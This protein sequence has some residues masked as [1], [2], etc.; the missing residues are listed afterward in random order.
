MSGV[1][2]RLTGQE[3]VRTFLEAAAAS[4]GD[5]YLFVGG[6][7]V[8]KRE[9]ARAFAA[10]ILCPRACGSCSICT[11]VEQAVHPDVSSFEPEGYTYPLELIREM[12]A[13]AAQ[14][15]MEGSRRVI[16]IEE[17]DRIAE[18]SQNALLKALEEPNPS[19]SWVLLARCAEPLLATLLSRCHVLEFAPVPEEALINLLASR[20]GLGRD[21]I[22]QVVTAA[23]GDLKRAVALASDATA[24]ELR[25]LAID[26]VAGVADRRMSPA[27]AL[28]VAD[29]LRASATAAREAKER[30]LGAEM[31]AF[32]QALGSGR[33]SAAARKRAKDRTKRTLRR[34]ETEV[35]CDF[36]SWLAHAYRDLAALSAGADP[37]EAGIPDEL[38]DLPRSEE[39]PS[40]GFWLQMVDSALEGQ[41]AILEN[42]QPML[43]V[44]SVLLGAVAAGDAPSAG[45]AISVKGASR[46]EPER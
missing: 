25:K 16:I 21:E 23:R 39:A 10:A 3:R 33:G 32:E 45:P 13:S 35:F 19:L 2:D 17:A 8:G 46:R 14:T 20:F 18:R 29:L 34:V 30:A 38:R 27:A 4:G 44:E 15:P 40:T 31:A 11:R 22:E 12:V 9:A 41:R 28:G 43:V 37:Q 24:R 1:W 7:G 26:A 36:L 6:P 5:S 42:A